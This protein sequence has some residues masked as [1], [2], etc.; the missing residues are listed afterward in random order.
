MT[1]CE[2]MRVEKTEI[3]EE[4]VGWTSPHFRRCCRTHSGEECPRR[5]RPRRS[6]LQLNRKAACAA[7]AADG[8]FWKGR[9]T[10]ADLAK[11][12]QETLAE[13]MARP[14]HT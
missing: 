13:I 7:F 5:R 1:E 11:I 14:G 6:A 12:S 4:V 2:M 10:G 8:Q 3:H 9:P